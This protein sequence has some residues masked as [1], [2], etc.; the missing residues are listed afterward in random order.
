MYTKKRLLFFIFNFICCFAFSQAVSVNKTLDS[1]INNTVVGKPQL[2][3]ATNY[4]IIDTFSIKKVEL[5]KKDSSIIVKFSNNTTK[6]IKA[7]NLWGQV[8]DFNERRRFYNGQTYTIWHTHAP[9]IYRVLKNN[10]AVYYYSESLTSSLYLLN[11][12]NINNNTSDTITKTV[13][14]N[15]MQDNKITNESI[16][17]PSTNI[18]ISKDSKNNEPFRDAVAETVAITIDITTTLYQSLVQLI[19]NDYVIDL[20]QGIKLK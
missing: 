6:K 5:H 9:Y 18:K 2:I 20:I 4:I 3:Q 7:V 8:T 14:N 13:L 11:T 17:N 12:E 10:N 1:I 19:Q 16:V 15:Y